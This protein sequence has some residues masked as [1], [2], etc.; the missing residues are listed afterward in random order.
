M[1]LSECVGGGGVGGAGGM[2]GGGIIDRQ[3]KE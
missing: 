2:G 3:S 1:I